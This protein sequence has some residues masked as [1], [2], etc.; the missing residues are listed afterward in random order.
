RILPTRTTLAAGIEETQ[1][2]EWVHVIGA[3]CS[4]H[5]A[6]E[7]HFGFGIEKCL[8]FQISQADRNT[9][10]LFPLSLHPLGKG[11]ILCLGVVNE[12]DLAHGKRRT[13]ETTIGIL[14][15]WIAGLAE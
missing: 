11:S 5:K 9:E 3:P 1:E 14:N 4:T 15:H 10:I 8:P 7:L 13:G 12:L 2:C 6:F